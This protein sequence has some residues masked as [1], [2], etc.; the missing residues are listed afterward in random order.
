[1]WDVPSR[2][3]RGD[4]YHV[5]TAR[6]KRL[7]VTVT[8]CV[9]LAACI[10]LSDPLPPAAPPLPRA[11]NT[12]AAD[13]LNR[14]NACAQA[15]AAAQLNSITTAT[16]IAEAASVACTTEEAH[17]ADAYV[18][19]HGWS[20]DELARLNLRRSAMDSAAEM[21]RKAALRVI[22]E[23]RKLPQPDRARPANAQPDK[24]T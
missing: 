10:L 17:Y 14:V 12:P 11:G 7:A 21:A 5:S 19:E 24:T 22:V 16:E 1:M 23:A 9:L 4:W 2:Q 6:V 15:Y 18:A 13:I 3:R 20:G 8:L